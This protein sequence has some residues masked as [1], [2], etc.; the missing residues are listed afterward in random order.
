MWCNTSIP[1]V[2]MSFDRQRSAP[3]VANEAATCNVSACKVLVLDSEQWQ[4]PQKLLL[5]FASKRAHQEGFTSHA[6]A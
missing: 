4:Q 3:L 2:L 1:N 5:R 6:V